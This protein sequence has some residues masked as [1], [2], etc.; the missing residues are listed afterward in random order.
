[1]PKEIKAGKLTKRRYSDEEKA[2]AVRLVCQLSRAL[3]TEHGT[4]QRVTEQLRYGV[5][6]AGKWVR[7]VDV[8]ESLKA[9]PSSE[10]RARMRALEQELKRLRR[11]KS[12]LRSASA[13]FL[14]C[15]AGPPIEGIVDY[16]N[17]H[18]DE[19]GS[20]DDQHL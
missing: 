5:E 15:G 3:G 18:R 14:R 4:V 16:T 13:F 11:T 6:M 10:D 12:I 20:N 2:H 7:Q 1:M 9:G 19:F 8:D 17:G